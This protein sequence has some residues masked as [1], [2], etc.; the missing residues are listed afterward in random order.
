MRKCATV[1]RA[2]R[3]PHNV[4]SRIAS[5]LAGWFL[6]M[7]FSWVGVAQFLRVGGEASSSRLGLYHVRCNRLETIAGMV[8]P[9]PG[10]P[11]LIEGHL[12][13]YRDGAESSGS[14]AESRHDQRC[15]SW[16]I[17]GCRF[18]V[19]I[20]SFPY[21]EYILHVSHWLLLL[22]AAGPY[23]TCIYCRRR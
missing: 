14:A 4:A 13:D 16:S 6:V 23:L 1:W 22:V 2:L 11:N 21:R 8:L 17:P 7:V 9:S 3:D 20:T 19:S 5:I 12:R 10:L 15:K 18:C